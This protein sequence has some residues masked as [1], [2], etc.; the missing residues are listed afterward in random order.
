M[1][2]TSIIQ[3]EQNSVFWHMAFFLSHLFD[4]ATSDREAER[5]KDHML[6]TGSLNILKISTNCIALC[7]SVWGTVYDKQAFLRGHL[8]D[9]QR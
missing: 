8:N 9:F 6:W 7:F 5:F 3:L 2:P 4:Q 1:F